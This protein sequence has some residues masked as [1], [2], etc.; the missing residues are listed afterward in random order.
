MYINS[1]TSQIKSPQTPPQTKPKPPESDDGKGKEGSILRDVASIGAGVA[2]GIAGGTYGF[3]E[4]LVKGG[5]KNYPKHVTTGA[6]IGKKIATPIGG[7]VGAIATGLA[8]AGAAAL[9]PVLTVVATGLRGVVGTGVSAIKQAPGAIVETGKKGADIGAGAG[10]KLGKIGEAVGTFVG[11][12][13]G[14]VAGIFVALGRGVPD[15]LKGAKEQFLFG[16]DMMKALPQATKETWNVVY[17]GA[18]KVAGG[19]GLLAGGA[20]GIGTGTV[21]TGVDG[22][23]N[24][25]RRGGEWG[26]I[27]SD[28]VGGKGDEKPVAPEPKPETKPQ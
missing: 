20:A 4:G 26:K 2:G 13:I 8:V 14:G 7:A 6:E 18:K 17:P 24:G 11:G 22:V 27:A 3:G 16:V 15:G 9:T 25:V 19:I 12:A 10:Q 1:S 5:I 28:Y 23:I 21:H